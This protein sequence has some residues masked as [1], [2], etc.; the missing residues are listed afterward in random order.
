MSSQVMPLVELGR[1]H[2]WV[3]HY[4]VFVFV[5]QSILTGTESACGKVIGRD[6][7]FTVRLR[8]SDLVAVGVLL[9]IFLFAPSQGP[10]SLSIC[11]RDIQEAK[12]ATLLENSLTAGPTHSRVAVRRTRSAPHV[13]VFRGA[14]RFNRQ[15]HALAR[16]RAQR[17]DQYRREMARRQTDPGDSP[18]R[19]AG[20]CG[21]GSRL[22]STDDWP[23]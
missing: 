23:R 20:P 7:P 1:V 8:R 15:R 10:S 19:G 2:S 3:P 14:I 22:E 5:V 6:E 21:P 11:V 13:P 12:E 17:G 16:C 18:S 9:F 4:L